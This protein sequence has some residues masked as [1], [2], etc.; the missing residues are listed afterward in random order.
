MRRKTGFLMLEMGSSKTVS[1]L[2]Y[3]SE[4]IRVGMAPSQGMERG[5]VVDLIQQEKSIR[6]ALE[7]LREEDLPE[8]LYLGISGEVFQFRKENVSLE[9]KDREVEITENEIRRLL[10]TAGERGTRGTAWETIHTIP[11]NYRV[12][13][14]GKVKNPLFMEGEELSTECIIVTLLATTQDTFIRC[15]NQAGFGV[16][17]IFFLP[18]T[19]GE[20]LLDEEEK[21]MG[22]I[23]IDAG[24]GI[25]DISVYREN[26]LRDLRVLP[27]GGKDLTLHI[28]HRLKIPSREAEK[29]KKEK[30]VALRFMADRET[31]K[32][33]GFSEEKEIDRRELA[34][35][36]EEWIWIYLSRIEELIRPHLKN[37]SAGM[38][39]CGGMA[40]LAGFSEA[41]SEYFSLPVRIVSPPPYA[42]LP[43]SPEYSSTW[44]F[45]KFLEKN[46]DREAVFSIPPY[47]RPFRNLL[48]WLREKI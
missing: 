17:R 28:A 13:K 12:G 47:L 41:L 23:M 8:S 40:N 6:Q 25:T 46:R 22:T 26:S 38:V 18:Y 19:T 33:Q 44:A 27:M 42:P 36:I 45:L 39:V 1:L 34:E 32:V 30:G 11:L 24:E 2:S 7:N 43:S 4:K 3:S 29:L 10:S 37:I 35:M 16:E 20:I 14:L 15:I 5:K 9:R 31:I 21:Q 48:H